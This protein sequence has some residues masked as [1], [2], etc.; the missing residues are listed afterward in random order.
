MLRNASETFGIAFKIVRTRSKGV[1][2]ARDGKFSC[3]TRRDRVE[4]VADG[5]AVVAG[6]LAVVRDCLAVVGDCLAIVGESAAMDVWDHKMD[7][8]GVGSRVRWPWRS[9]PANI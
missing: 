5:L 3:Q 9:V 7:P 4:M 2:T 8:E 6:S 1:G